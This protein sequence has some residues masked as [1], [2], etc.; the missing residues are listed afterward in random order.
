MENVANLQLQCVTSDEADRIIESLRPFP[1]DDVATSDWKDQRMRVEQLNHAAHACAAQK[2]DNFIL[3][4]LLT[5]DK[6]PVLLHEL[7]VAEAMRKR[8]YMRSAGPLMQAPA[9]MY[10]YAYYEGIL[11]NL[12]TCLMFHEEAVTGFGD[13][14]PELID[15]AWRSCV[16]TLLSDPTINEVPPEVDAKEA[17]AQSDDVRFAQQMRELDVTRAMGCV[18]CLWYVVERI[19]SLPLA[20]VN[21]VLAHNDLVCGF[22]DLLDREPWVRRSAKKNTKFANGQWQEVDRQNIL[23]VTAPEAHSWFALHMMLCDRNC[24]TKYQYT[25]SKKDA[26]LRV[27]RRL[28]EPIIDQI[29]Q[30][31]DV[32]RALEELSFMEPPTGTEEKFKATLII[33]QMPRIMS[34]LNKHG[35]WDKTADVF[36][37]RCTSRDGAMQDAMRMSRMF[38]AMMNNEE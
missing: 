38:D 20:C 11:V 29:P 18:S 26:I 23:V 7:L 15:Y 3:S 32:Q 6:L 37:D 34:V 22:A 17:L 35:N 9:G 10:M 2:K 13:D 8:V 28:N 33:E 30:L 16:N 36:V 14:L 12:L 25:K 19:N 1:I 27:K 5:H 4:A 31:Q 21:C 24:R